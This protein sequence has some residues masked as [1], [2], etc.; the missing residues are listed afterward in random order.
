MKDSIVIDM[1]YAAYDIIDG[2]PAEHRHHVFEG[3]AD[4]I[5]SDEDGLWVPLTQEH[6]EG[7]LSV[8]HNKEIRNLMHIVGQLAWEKNRVAAGATEK[9][10]RE[11]FRKRYK[12]SYL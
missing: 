11:M 10:A 9:E 4:R 6:H 7:K 3:T 2:S 1:D 8:H 5:K 12:K